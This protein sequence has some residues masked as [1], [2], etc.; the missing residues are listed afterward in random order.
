[1]LHFKRVDDDDLDDDDLDEDVFVP[2]VDDVYA[3]IGVLQGD[4]R[5][6]HSLV[7]DRMFVQV[8]IHQE[9]LELHA[10]LDRI[11]ANLGLV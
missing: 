8:E 4:L 1:M 11:L 9:I 6:L 5:S 7:E 3:E 10:K 2:D